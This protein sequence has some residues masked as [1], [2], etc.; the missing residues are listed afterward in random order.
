MP[1]DICQGR[2]EDLASAVEVWKANQAAGGAADDPMDRSQASTVNADLCEVL[3]CSACWGAQLNRSDGVVC[4]PDFVPG[5]LHFKNKFCENCK[6]G[7]VLPLSRVCGLTNEMAQ[8]F[9]NKRTEGFWN[10]LPDSL[11]GRRY[12]MINNTVGSVGPQLV[13]FYEQPPDDL[14]WL[15]VPEHWVE[16][17]FVRLCVAKGTLVPAKTLRCG[18]PQASPKRKITTVEPTTT[19]VCPKKAHRSSF[20]AASGR[21]LAPSAAAGESSQLP[22]LRAYAAPTGESTEDSLRRSAAIAAARKHAT[23]TVNAA[24]VAARDSEGVSL[25]KVIAAGRP[26]AAETQVLAPHHARGLEEQA[27]AA[28]AAARVALVQGQELQAYYSKIRE[29]EAQLQNLQMLRTQLQAMRD[30]L[31]GGL[32][33]GLQRKLQ[34]EPP[35]GVDRAP[36]AAPLRNVATAKDYEK[37]RMESHLQF[38]LLGGGEDALV[39]RSS[40]SNGPVTTSPTA[41]DV[42]FDTLAAHLLGSPAECIPD[43]LSE[44]TML[45]GDSLEHFAHALL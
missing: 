40:A 41:N 15:P 1:T 35:A 13:L 25:N 32:H 22:P 9:T 28:R 38:A 33:G 2:S 39:P 26:P 7:I 36:N 27:A 18:Q 19:L 24:A 31:I 29:Y 42:A 11:G 10:R 17:G 23:I 14:Q 12:R 37:A 4:E 44:D 5:K 6:E 43:F 16:D 30:G 20:A 34:A 8:L 21:V 45:E 3:E